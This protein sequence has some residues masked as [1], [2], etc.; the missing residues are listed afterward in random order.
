MF[1]GFFWPVCLFVCWCVGVLVCWCVG[2][3]SLF[4]FAVVRRTPRGGG[5]PPP[6]RTARVR[7]A[8]ARLPS[9]HVGPRAVVMATE[10]RT[11]QPDNNRSREL[12]GN[13]RTWCTTERGEQPNMVHNRT[14][15]T[16][17]HGAQPNVVHNRTW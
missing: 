8:Q 2:A 17:E 1:L 14:W 12:T 11:N 3:R 16:T 4:V 9:T 15:C 10:A 7:S 13:D 6:V 5:R